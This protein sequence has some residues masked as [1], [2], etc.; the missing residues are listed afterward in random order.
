MFAGA[1]VSVVVDET[2]DDRA[3]S[4]VK[5]LSINAVANDT[6]GLHPVLVKV[7][8]VGKVNAAVI[9]CI[10][11]KT[12]TLHGVEFADVGG[13]I[14]DSAASM[15]KAFQER[16]VP[17]CKNA[18]H[19]TCV[20]HHVNIIG[21]TMQKSFPFVDKLVRDTKRASHFSSGKRALFKL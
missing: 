5:G 16:I 8:F 7:K 14:S 21:A 4:V 13:F 15:K 11:M 17:L 3:K 12:L 10:I 6:E 19:V 1:T 18:V 2:M 20:A 9:S